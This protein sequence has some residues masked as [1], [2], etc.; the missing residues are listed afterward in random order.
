[1]IPVKEDEIEAI[2]DYLEEHPE[3][4]R[5]TRRPR[6]RIDCPFRDKKGRR[7]SIYPVRPLVCRLMGV[8]DQCRCPNG[9]SAMIDGGTY[10]GKFN[11]SDY[12]LLNEMEF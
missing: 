5:V 11:L 8:A 10:L 6:E 3:A 7:C 2:A 9:N 4:L 1:M 12:N